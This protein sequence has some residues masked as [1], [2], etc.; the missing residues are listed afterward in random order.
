MVNRQGRINPSRQER[1]KEMKKWLAVMLAT[2]VAALIWTSG[3]LAQEEMFITKGMNS[4]GFQ[5]MFTITPSQDSGGSATWNL[6]LFPSYSRFLTPHVYAGIG[7]GI[8]MMGQ[9]GMT[10]K[11]LSPMGTVGLKLYSPTQAR[12]LFGLEYQAGFTIMSTSIPWMSVDSITGRTEEK[13]TT[14]TNAGFSM[15]WFA[16]PE[17]VLKPGMT[18]KVGYQPRLDFFE[19][20]SWQHQLAAGMNLYF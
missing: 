7:G 3:A 18:L 6:N 9:E 2:V 15:G 14:I 16:G 13:D 19:K 12:V 1:K 4:L 8:T 20:A 10:T 17:F 11:M 5:G